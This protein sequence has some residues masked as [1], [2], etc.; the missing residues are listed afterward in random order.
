MKK[1]VFHYFIFYLC[2]INRAGGFAPR[3]YTGNRKEEGGG[4]KSRISSPWPGGG[5][6][7]RREAGGRLCKTASQTAAGDGFEIEAQ[8]SLSNPSC[9]LRSPFPISQHQQ[10]GFLPPSR[11]LIFLS[12]KQLAGLTPNTASRSQE[13]QDS[14][15]W[16]GG[17]WTTRS[18]LEKPPCLYWQGTV[19]TRGRGYCR[20]LLTFLHLTKVLALV[21]AGTQL[22]KTSHAQQHPADSKRCPSPSSRA[23]AAAAQAPT[24]LFVCRILHPNCSCFIEGGKGER[25]TQKITAANAEL[26]VVFNLMHSLKEKDAPKIK[27]VHIKQALKRKSSCFCPFCCRMRA[28][29]LAA[30]SGEGCTPSPIPHTRALLDYTSEIRAALKKKKMQRKSRLSPRTYPTPEHGGRHKHKKTFS[31]LSSLRSPTQVGAHASQRCGGGRFPPSPVNLDQTL[32]PGRPRCG[33]PRGRFEG[34]LRPQMQELMTVGLL[35]GRVLS[36]TGLGAPQALA[37]GF[38]VPHEHRREDGGTRSPGGGRAQLP[39]SR[40]V[41]GS[42]EERVSPFPSAQLFPPIP[43][44]T[45]PLPATSSSAPGGAITFHTFSIYA[46]GTI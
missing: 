42:P 8:I 29:F 22:C 32:R 33:A 25:T 24:L 41:P 18:H 4:K 2:S 40:A 26:W 16:E 11:P 37:A 17:A 9:F 19:Q 6:N 7:R 10:P 35:T 27:L 15:E 34:K 28:S 14:E 30:R 3:I 36:F 38:L 44:S 5:L 20:S 13:H 21:A 12:S 23:R 45:Q 31:F 39:R 1:L 43:A 46:L